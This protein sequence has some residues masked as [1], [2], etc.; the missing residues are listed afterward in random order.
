MEARVW[1]G[2]KGRFNPLQRFEEWTLSLHR[3]TLTFRDRN[4]VTMAAALSEVEL[5]FP[6]SM[7]GAGFVLAARGVR[8]YVWFYDPFAGRSAFLES[9]DKDAAQ[10]EGAKRWFEGRRAAKPWLKAL[11]AAA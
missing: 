8:A 6:L 7:T 11:R 10:L 5:S 4:G 9:G 3:D 1:V 2:K